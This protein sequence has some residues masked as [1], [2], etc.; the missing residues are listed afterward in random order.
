MRATS[1]VGS[2]NGVVVLEAGILWLTSPLSVL[3]PTGL[4]NV[5]RCERAL[6]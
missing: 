6:I 1:F 4:F 2:W 3:D 5:P